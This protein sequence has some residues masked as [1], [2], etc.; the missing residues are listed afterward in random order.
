MPPEEPTI[1][2]HRWWELNC[3]QD[4]EM[5]SEEIDSLVDVEEIYRTCKID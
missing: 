5:A 3:V 2:C 4:P 1:I